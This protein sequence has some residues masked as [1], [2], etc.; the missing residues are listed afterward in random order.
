MKYLKRGIYKWYLQL[1]NGIYKW[2]VDLKLS[3][4]SGFWTDLGKRKGKLSSEEKWLWSGKKCVTS[5]I[6]LTR[7]KF[8]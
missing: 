5:R 2:D 7:A 8:L 3:I 6:S 1:Q 4:E